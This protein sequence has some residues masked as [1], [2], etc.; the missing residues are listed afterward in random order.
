MFDSDGYPLD[1]DQEDVEYLTEL[2]REWR[3]S[4]DFQ[5]MPADEE[6]AWLGEQLPTTPHAP[7][8]ESA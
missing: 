7:N 6:N 5:P 8:S 1:L 2:R 3:N 4:P